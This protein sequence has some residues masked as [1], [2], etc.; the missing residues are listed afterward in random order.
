MTAYAAALEPAQADAYLSAQE[1]FN[2][3]II[4]LR[5]QQAQQMTHSQLEQFLETDGRELLRL[6]F[7]AHLDERGPGAVSEPVVD[8]TGHSHT[9]QRLHSRSIKTIFGAV[10]ITRQGYGG[11]A[12]ESLHPLDAQLNLPPENYSHT[13]QQRLAEAAAKESFD[14]VVAT[15]HQQTGLIIP[16]R[17]AEESARRSAQDFELFYARQRAQTAPEVK[18]TSDIL[19]ISAD[20]KGVPMLKADLQAATRKA[21]EERKP[22]LNH[23]RSKGEKAH[24]KRMGTVAAVYT[25]APFVRTPAQ[26]VRELEPVRDTAPARPRPEDKRVWASIKHPPET[27]IAQAFEEAH[28]RDPKQT[29]QWVALVDG[30]PLQ[31]GLLL[32]AATDYGVELEIILDLIHVLEYLWK[33]AWVLHAEGDQEAETWVSQRLTEILRGRSS[34]VAAGIRRRATLRGLSAKQR[35]PLDTCANYL[36]KYGKFLRYDRYLAAGYPIASG[37]I[38]GACRYLVKDRME[39]TGARWSLA[40]AE[41]VLQLRSLRASG[42]FEQYWGFHLQQEYKRNHQ[43]H[44]AEGRLPTPKTKPEGKAKGSHLKLVK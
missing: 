2:S 38:E 24:T 32:C 30:N 43:F 25:I 33:A 35:A 22:R 13:L 40:G 39:I 9:H 10:T 18:A 1:Q 36:L 7:Q 15:I 4:Q 37:V 12:L 29:K 26:I 6:M 11:R 23:R 31:L 34:Q 27:I 20:G 17:Q 41:A 21:A 3:I 16:K 19:V 28:R 44:Y 42:D 8:A 5:S 14:E